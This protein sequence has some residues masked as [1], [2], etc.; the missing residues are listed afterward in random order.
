MM[1]LHQPFPAAL[2]SGHTPLELQIIQSTLQPRVYG[3]SPNLESHPIIPLN[4]G[5]AP[6]PLYTHF[7]FLGDHPFPLANAGLIFA[8][9]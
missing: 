8:S 5:R 9:P 4:N 1:G 6:G 7:H 3:F 2:G